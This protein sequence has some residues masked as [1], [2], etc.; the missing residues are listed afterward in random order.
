MADSEKEILEIL[1]KIHD[2]L[3]P[4]STCFQGQ[5]EEIQRQRFGSKL[6]DLEALLTTPER[7]KVFSLLFSPRRLSQTDIAREAGTTQPTVS[8]FISMLL[9]RGFIERKK[10][11][12]GTITYE[13]KFNLRKLMEAQNERD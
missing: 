13:D 11:E 9:K 5:Y 1:R 3:V 12:T 8:R 4:I 2:R 7:R 10:D 6:E